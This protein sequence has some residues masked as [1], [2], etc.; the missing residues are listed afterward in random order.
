MFKHM[1]SIEIYGQGKHSSA[2]F[3]TCA[4]VFCKKLKKNVGCGHHLPTQN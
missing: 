3:Y 4:S 2:W 1:L